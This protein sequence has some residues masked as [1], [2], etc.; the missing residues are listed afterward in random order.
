M[1]GEG[2]ILNVSSTLGL[3][4]MEGAVAYCAA[5]GGG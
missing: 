1:N 4:A 5:K 2:S 3:R